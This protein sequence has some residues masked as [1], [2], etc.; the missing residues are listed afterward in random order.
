MKAV[1]GL[2][3]IPAPAQ[4]ER[5][6]TA[7]F[8]L[9]CA[10]FFL[11]GLASLMDEVVW[12]KYLHLTLGST[13]SAAATLLAVFMGGLA[14]GSWLF[15]RFAPR[16][17]RPAT[18][19]AL[20]EAGVAVF[21]LATPL[22]FDAIH[23]GYVFA[24]RHVGEGPGTL[25]AVRAVLATVALLPPTIL[26]GGTF[27]VLSRLVERPGNPGRR[28]AAL[29]AA[30]TAGAV[31]G[32]VLAGFVLILKVGLH[33]TLL[34][35]ACVSFVA[36]LLALS[37]QR[38]P[39]P[40]VPDLRRE[41]PVR[42]WIAVAFLTGAGAMAVEVLWTR[43]LVL[44]LGS[45]V[46]S[47]SLMLAIYLSG[48]AAGS[49]A[50]TILR[51]REPRRLLA[52]S[53]L[54]LGGSFLLQVL[55][56][57][58]YQKFLV[59][60]ATRLIHARTYTDVLASEAIVTAAYLLP[61]TF[62]M[63]L[64]F[65]VLLRAAC[66]SPDTAP[67]EAGSLYAANTLGS[68]AGA[69]VAG[70]LA[71]PAIGTQNSLLAACFLAAAVGLL[72]LPRSWP[73]RIAPA[74]FAAIAFVPQPDGVILSSGPFSD[75]PRGDVLFYDEDVTATVS[76]KRYTTPPSLS[77]E[78]NGVNVAGTSPDLLMVQKLQGHLPLLLA[79]RPEKVLH[80]GFGSGGTAHSVSLHPVSQIRVL[81]I[82]PEVLHA[83]AR[84]FQPVNHG[85]LGDPRLTASINDGR[86]F[87]LASPESFDVILSDSI[88]PRY[89]G[90]GS[91]YT[92][93]YFRLCARRL[94]PGGV[95]SMWLPMY[96][97]LPENY[98]S[99]VRALRD[100]FPHVS[101]WYPH[102]V[103]NSFTIVI[104]TPEKT[105]RLPDIAMRIESNPRVRSDLAE[106]GADDPAE[107]LSYLM[108]GPDAVT[109]WVRDEVPH[110][111]DR[112]AVEYESGRTLEYVRTWRWI[113]DELLA[114]RS[115]I[116]DFVAGL[117]EGDPLAERVRE[118]FRSA[119]PILAAHKEKLE[120]LTRTEM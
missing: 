78:L 29:Y 1:D 18:T 117:S 36:A 72:V 100:V 65:A 112:P 57:P 47:F 97:M 94:R 68:I 64:T 16:L 49:F 2:G 111:D 32:V 5:R 119:V 110:L 24:F 54:A 33:A 83:A 61:P 66:R 7:S 17:S 46:Y 37:L 69:L 116:E 3:A 28:S 85:V 80:V 86:N 99:I 25:L 95:V 115:R 98:R 70:F 23:R 87:I 11:S 79:G 15:S 20:L 55:A 22:L 10:V 34:S 59:A 13:T 31:A 60:I 43:I 90:N 104:A 56:F 118:K 105:V 45:S 67:R 8:A 53:Q 101:I 51:A 52:A 102:S 9:A 27:P 89:A 63:G 82:S 21:A 96:S 4:G 77:L 6:L 12:F 58:G 114:R 91:L 42:L 40:A 48:L 44:Y 71:I 26:M 106:I 93:D 50:G 103:E 113:F 39:L 76:V 88:H 30:N 62:L 19:Y 109:A 108:L 38:E 14:L 84:F 81:E 75:V 107:L 41:R 120:R 92:E 73:V 35:S 74:A